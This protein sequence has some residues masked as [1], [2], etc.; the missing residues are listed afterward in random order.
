[1]RLLNMGGR[2]VQGARAALLA[3]FGSSL[4]LGGM[5][6]VPNLLLA[7]YAR[8]G[9]NES[10][11]MLLLHL[12]RLETLEGEPFPTPERLSQFMAVDAAKVRELMA[13]L[14]EKKILHVVRQAD[15]LQGRH[16]CKYCWQDLMAR[17][18]E[19]WLE[20]Q[21]SPAA[22]EGQAARSELYGAFE[23][24]FGRP[25]SPL[26]SAQVAAWC[27]RYDP[28]LIREAL[29]LAVLRGVYNFRY[30]DSILHQWEKNNVRTLREAQEYEAKFRERR[31]RSRRQK[32]EGGEEKPKEEKKYKDLYLS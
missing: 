27:E 9:L 15:P 31:S 29:R 8:L 20:E 22:E 12:F 13:S 3:A 24:E 1:M 18:A 2:K 11:V 10:E 5:V 32:T 4:W 30:M 19:V 7:Y 16:V 25:L 23:R 17:L 28:E 26:E 21:G 14:M 6:A